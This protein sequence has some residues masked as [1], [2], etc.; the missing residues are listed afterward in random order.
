[1]RKLISL[2][3]KFDDVTLRRIAGNDVVKAVEQ[4]YRTEIKS[5][6]AEIIC[7]ELGSKVL[8]NK[9]VRLNIIDGASAREIDGLAELAD[10]NGCGMVEKAT[11]L[12][13]HFRNYS[14][15]KSK[16]FASWLSLSEEYSKKPQ[17]DSR[18][19]AEKITIEY[20][21]QVRLKG[22]LH[23]YQ[24]NVKDQI[25]QKL[26]TPGSR[27]MVQMP[28]GSGKTYTALETMIDTLR[29]P[30]YHGFVVWIVNTNELAEQALQ[31]FKAL[32]QVKGDREIDC[33]RLFNKFSPNFE[34]YSKG[35]VVFASYDIIESAL[36][37]SQDF[38]SK[39]LKN[40]LE[41]TEYLVVDEAHSAIAE[42]YEDCIRLFINDNKTRLLGLSATPFREDDA[43]EKQLLSLFHSRLISIKDDE[44]NP[45]NDPIKH[46]QQ[47]KYLANVDVVTLNSDVVCDKKDEAS[48][49]NE[50]ASD[51]SRNF[52]IVEQIKT[53]VNDGDQT[54][55]FACTKQHV[56]AL[57]I[58]CKKENLNV[59]FITGDVPQVQRLKLIEDFQAGI[60]NVLI[61]LDI[62]STGIDI[63]ALDRLVIT[64]PVKSAILYS[65]IVGRALR[66]PLNGGNE[67]NKIVN[68]LDNIDYFPSID[69]LFKSFSNAWE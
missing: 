36:K 67:R 20:G 3:S 55:V 48:V 60:L 37:S 57:Y 19:E 31:S 54:L 7:L 51:S 18:V 66:G 6:L 14:I 2:I 58:L 21:Q 46:L 4:S 65:Q 11:K 1:M 49:L 61:N 9:E 45:I 29:A 47:H 30:F 8:D 12:Q 10:I 42:T 25:Q 68:V 50:L 26:K 34:S 17:V 44:N 24:K 27:V 28:T 5:A 53:A 52:M 40:L 41:R 23:S 38:K 22:Y 43:I 56:L 16:I 39:K 33:F 13:D 32:W 62:L 63:P 15:S 69:H 59:G 64:R 35:G